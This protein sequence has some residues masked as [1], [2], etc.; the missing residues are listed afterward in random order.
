MVRQDLGNNGAGGEQ[1]SA[2]DLDLLGGAVLAEGVISADPPVAVVTVRLRDHRV[3][4]GTA[5]SY[6]LLVR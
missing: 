4:P 1:S 2:A 5:A 6:S 3:R